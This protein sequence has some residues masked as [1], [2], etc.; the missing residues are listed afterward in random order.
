MGE[1]NLT[2]ECTEYTEGDENMGL[3]Y[4]EESYVIRGAIYEVYKT[5]GAGFWR[6]CIKRPWKWSCLQEVFCSFLKKK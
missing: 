2:T 6:L 1:C 3:I 4:V 5:L